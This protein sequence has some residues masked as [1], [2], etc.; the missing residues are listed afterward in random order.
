MHLQIQEGNKMTLP[1]EAR[2]QAFLLYCLDVSGPKIA[3]QVGLKDDKIIFVWAK[4]FNWQE[5]R[6]QSRKFARENAKINTVDYQKKLLNA[7]MGLWAS[8]ISSKQG[9]NTLAKQTSNR[10]MMEAIKTF[11]LLE[12]L[13]TEILASTTLE[14]IEKKLDDKYDRSRDVH[15][16]NRKSN[17]QNGNNP[18]D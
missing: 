2:E 9:K 17:P 4:K 16:N 3:E 6:D 10:D 8:K 13:P 15:K 1:R 11:R 7:L 14:E 5:K 18:G 12:G